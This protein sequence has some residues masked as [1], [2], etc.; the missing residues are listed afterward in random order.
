MVV[1]ET[2]IRRGAHS[3]AELSSYLER[4]L[5]VGRRS[6]ALRMLFGFVDDFRGSEPDGQVS[7]VQEAPPPTGATDI[8]AAL[9]AV[10]EFC[11]VEAGMETPRWAMEPSRMARP[12]LFVASNPAFHAYVMANTPISFARRG[13]FVAR[14]VFARV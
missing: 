3:L 5:A 6:D 10:A 7:L 8:D 14:E 11:C 4:E 12:W 9:A 2:V 13:V 1:T